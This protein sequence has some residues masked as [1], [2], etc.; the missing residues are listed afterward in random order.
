M[1]APRLPLDQ[2]FGTPDAKRR[3]TRR[4]FATIA[5]RYDVIT[6]LLSFGRDQAWKVDL[7]ERARR[8]A[9]RSARSIWRVAP[10]TLRF[11]RRRVA[12]PSWDSISRRE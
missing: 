8:A 12:R 6:R 9:G 10:A 2:A 1:T 5:D 11:S 4:L 3:Y 7:I